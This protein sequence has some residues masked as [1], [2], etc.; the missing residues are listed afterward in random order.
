[1]ATKADHPPYSE[2][3]AEAIVLLKERAGSSPHAICRVIGEGGAAAKLSLQRGRRRPAA[4]N[5][6]PALVCRPARPPP[7]PPSDPFAAALRP[8]HCLPAAGEKY[9]NKLKRGI[10]PWEKQVR[11]C[12]AWDQFSPV[13]Y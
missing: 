1:M 13:A 2:M 4:V 11:P 12:L 3:I 8:A 9:G 7:R 5:G 6:G 10:L